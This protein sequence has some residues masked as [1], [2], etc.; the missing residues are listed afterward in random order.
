MA[1]FNNPNNPRN[2]NRTRNLNTKG[3]CSCGT[4]TNMPL[5]SEHD[6]SI[7]IDNCTNGYTAYC[8][9]PTKISDESYIPYN[10]NLGNCNC[11]CIDQNLLEPVEPIKCDCD[12]YTFR[13]C[14]NVLYGYNDDIVVDI[15]SIRTDGRW[16]RYSLESNMSDY[17]G[18]SAYEKSCCKICGKIENLDDKCSCVGFDLDS[19]M[20]NNE[21]ERIYDDRAWTCSCNPKSKF[22]NLGECRKI[23][24]I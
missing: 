3:T 19:V 11:T 22:K 12:R 9:N 16:L 1:N 5:R 24:F 21:E 20:Y 10:M 15:N 18:I 6:C 7:K 4:D 13:H 23:K 8:E 2:L 14:N 17:K